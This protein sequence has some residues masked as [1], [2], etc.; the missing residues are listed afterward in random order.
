MKSWSL[1][2][3]KSSGP[4]Q[5]C[6]GIALTLLVAPRS[7]TWVCGRLLV[8]IVGS[9]SAGGMDVCREFCVLSGRDLF[10]GL[11]TRPEKS[12]RVWCV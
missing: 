9:N 12:Y 6:N 5:D 11:I 3:L 1:N 4:V 10:D 2:L 7:K 8:E